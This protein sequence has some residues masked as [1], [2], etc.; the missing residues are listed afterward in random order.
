M[1]EQERS[2][3]GEGYR[4]IHRNYLTKFRPEER[5]TVLNDAIKDETAKSVFNAQFDVENGNMYKRSLEEVSKVVGIT[6][7]ETRDIINTFL[8]QV[9][10]ELFETMYGPK[11]ES[12]QKIN[13]LGDEFQNW[14]VVPN[15]VITHLNK[16]GVKTLKDLLDRYQQKKSFG[17]PI[18][19]KS[20]ADIIKQLHERGLIDKVE[21]PGPE[22]KNLKKKTQAPPPAPT[23]NA[24]GKG[25]EK[26][27]KPN[28]RWWELWNKHLSKIEDAVLRVNMVR[29]I[30]P[31][32]Q[33]KVLSARF[34][35]KT[36]EPNPDAGTAIAEKLGLAKW[37]P[38]SITEK[39]IQKLME[40][41]PK[42]AR[43]MKKDPTKMAARLPESIED[44]EISAEI[45]K[46]LKKHKIML[47]ADLLKKTEAEA[48]EMVG[49][50]NIKELRN[51]L[52]EV[53]EGFKEEKFPI[54][55]SLFP[56]EIKEDLKQFGAIAEQ[57]LALNKKIAHG[58]DVW[59][60]NLAHMQSEIDEM[61]EIQEGHANKLGALLEKK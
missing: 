53:G 42:T 45:V 33:Y 36:G 37:A 35:L 48:L 9:D 61:R 23:K 24:R 27:A 40:D 46:L 19:H 14:I 8:P 28:E 55:P 43:R 38:Y 22:K 49:A 16:S 60:S 51:S 59:K 3:W 39:A 56:A 1:V 7:T 10:K 20:T 29:T 5:F 25:K 31:A 12:E 57:A 26:I 17:V 34:N 32:Q 47:T 6:K 4:R 41:L 30:L 18:R 44:L 2:R 13:L 50:H 21:L 11:A 52:D 58:F 54:M 15:G